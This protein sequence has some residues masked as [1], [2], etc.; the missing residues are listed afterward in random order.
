MN[1]LSDHSKIVSVFKSSF[2]KK[3]DTETDN[4][5]WKGRGTLYIWDKSTK[6]RFFNRLKDSKNEIEEI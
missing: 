5:K 4:Y 1:E 6:R 3:C 2:P